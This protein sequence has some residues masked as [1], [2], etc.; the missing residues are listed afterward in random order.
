M[1]N[2]FVC[3][4]CQTVCDT[5]LSEADFCVCPFCE[6]LP[7]VAERVA[8]LSNHYLAEFNDNNAH[9]ITDADDAPKADYLSYIHD[10]IRDTKRFPGPAWPT[11][12]TQWRGFDA[13]SNQTCYKIAAAAYA[14]SQALAIAY[15]EIEDE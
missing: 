13:I 4:Q 1:A 9:G 2:Q 5:D 11:W 12:A 7:S 14:Y 8:W 3:Y 6:A 10:I 15:K